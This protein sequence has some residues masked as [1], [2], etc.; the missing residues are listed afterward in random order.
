MFWIN[1]IFTVIFLVEAV[2]KITGLGPRWYFLDSWNILDF[3]VVNLALIILAMDIQ[4]KEYLCEEN[5]YGGI[6]VLRIFRVI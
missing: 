3:V 4:T 6:S 1:V 2:I 5:V